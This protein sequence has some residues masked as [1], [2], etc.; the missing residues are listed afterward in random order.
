M[1]IGMACSYDQEKDVSSTE[2]TSRVHG[3]KIHELEIIV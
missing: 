2:Y 1:D 3:Q